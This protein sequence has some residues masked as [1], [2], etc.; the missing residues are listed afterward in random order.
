M[1]EDIPANHESGLLPI[2]DCQMAVVGGCIVHHHYAKPMASL[3][4]VLQRS[5]MSM[6]AKQAI[7]VQEGCRRLR[8]CSPWL[9]WEEKLTHINR[10]MAQIMWAGYTQK[11]R[12]T[13]AHRILGK[14]DRNLENLRLHNRPLYRSKLQRKAQDTR[15]NKNTWF[16][17][18]GATATIMVPETRDSTLAKRLR[19]IV[20]SVPGPKGTHVKVV[21]RPG[22]PIMRGISSNNPFKLE[23]CPKEDCPMN[24]GGQSCKGK[25]STENILYRATCNRC[26]K[27][28]MDRGIPEDDIIQQQYIGETS[29]SLRVRSKQHLIDYSRCLRQTSTLT[30]TDTEEEGKLSSFILDHKLDK[31]RD[32][33][34]FDPKLDVKF[35]VLENFRDP[36][37]RQI[38]EAVR[39]KQAVDFNT[40]T[41]NREKSVHIFNINRKTEYFAPQERRAEAGVGGHY[42]SIKRF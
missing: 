10:L 31:H 23:Q 32:D 30:R 27:E 33:E 28:Q 22:P 36:I 15:A 14:Q 38:R 29:R 5:S 25:C 17:A 13:I 41:D 26:E 24:R 2:L 12:E 6:G 39:I 4:V 3:E 7:L 1:K 16:R 8:N 21:E 37:T 11:T 19:I 9:P 35:S 20:A 34:N 40:Y 18:E 42:I